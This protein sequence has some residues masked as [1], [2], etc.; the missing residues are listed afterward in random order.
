MS[1]GSNTIDTSYQLDNSGGMS[2]DTAPGIHNAAHQ[3]SAEAT[4]GQISDQEAG[5][6]SAQI[7]ITVAAL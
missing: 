6:Y 5:G 4:L 1:N 3:V 7:V 2:F